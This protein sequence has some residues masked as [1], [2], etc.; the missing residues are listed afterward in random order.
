MSRTSIALSG[1]ILVV[2][3]EPEIVALIRNV[4]TSRGYSVVGLSNSQEAP[5]KCDSFR[6]DVCILDFRMP[7]CSGSVLLDTIKQK[8]PTVEVIFLTADNETALA[9]D[10]MR[11]GAIDF[12]LKPVELNQLLLSVNRALEHRR[13]TMENQIYRGHLEQLVQ[14]KTRALNDALASLGYVHSVTLDMLSTA[15]DFRDRSTMGHSR[16][17][18]D[19]TVGVAKL[20]GVTGDTLV[21]IE[22][23]ALLHD[24]GK[25]KIPDSILWKPAKLTEE[26]WT[27]MR[28]HPELG[29]EFMSHIEF[30]KDAAGIVY[31]HHEKFNGEGYPRKLRGEQIP[32]GARVFAVVD[33]V[34]AMIYKRPYNTPILFRAAVDEVRRCSGTQFDPDIVEI[35]LAYLADH[36]PADMK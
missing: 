27:V 25:L 33:A 2:D 28:Q 4:L 7:H 24:I 35:T 10:L 26:E 22:H 3:D 31:T 19:L 20:M 11:R 14:E 13:L 9:V 12:L 30:L 1:K 16:R 15:L 18:A 29:F 32:F 6:P 21:Q 36:V 5:S 34:D 8:D 17:V 23:G